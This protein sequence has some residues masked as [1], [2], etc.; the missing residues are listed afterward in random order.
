[1]LGFSS[2]HLFAIGKADNLL[3]NTNHLYGYA[4][5]KN[6]NSELFNY[7]LGM[8]VV[9]RYNLT[10]YEGNAAVRF[11]HPTGLTT[12]PREISDVGLT[13]RS[14]NQMAFLMGLNLTN[15]FRVGYVYNQSL[16]V[17]Y[18]A[19]TTHEFMLEY[20]I[21]SK[22]ASACHCHNLDYWD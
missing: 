4:I 17:G 9:N 5:Y 19:N 8:Q 7:N 20:R 21:P 11:K 13:Y 6:T 1:V 2:T 12:G 14:T 22:A 18:S 3:L 10:V 16:S 15:N